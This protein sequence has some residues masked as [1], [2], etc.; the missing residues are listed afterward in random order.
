MATIPPNLARVA[1]S[2]SGDLLLRNMRRTNV[3]LLRLQSQIASGKKI[4]QPSDEP[5]SISSINTLQAILDRIASQNNLVKRAQDVNDVT[6]Q[7]LS[8]VSTALLQAQDVASSQVGV[9]TNAETRANQAAVVDGIIDGLLRIAN[10]DYDNLFVFGGL[11]SDT[12]PFTSE[13]GGIR[14]VGSRSNLLGETADTAF[15]LELNSNG[16]ASLG[17]LSRRV[18]SQVDLD[19][20]V[21]AQTRIADVHGARDLGVAKGA[22]VLDVDGTQVQVDLTTSDTL[23]DVVTRINSAINAIDNTAGSLSINPAGFTLTASAGHTIT[24]GDLGTGVTAADLGINLTA[25]AG[26]V[27]GGD[28]DPRLILITPLSQLGVSVDLA[29]GIRIVNGSVTKDISF[30]AATT[31]QDLINAVD[32]AHIG[33]RLEINAAG[34]GFNL[35]NEVSGANMSVGELGGSTAADLGLRSFDASTS[36][37]DFNHGDGVRILGNS[38]ADFRIEV[39]DGTLVDVS[40][41]GATDVQDVLDAV[42]TAGAGKVS[43][44]LAST[45]NGIVLTDLSGGAGQFKVI[46]INNSFAAQD[47]GISKNATGSTTLAGDD[48]AQIRTESVFT[49]LIALRDALRNNDIGGITEAGT[50]IQADLSRVA[51]VRA[52]IGVRSDR[53]QNELARNEDRTTQTQSILSDLRDTDMTEAISRFTQLQQQLQAN[54]Q[55]AGQLLRL[56]L[57]DFLQ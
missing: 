22:V 52:T 56:T 29:G 15:P 27:S 8:D 5:Q 41:T 21:A 46:Q 13:F 10:R 57:L 49:H 28:L 44:A 39:G 54:L 40:L 32:A 18:T 25:S 42:N 6:D 2:L 17:A 11:R 4:S 16:D 33:A 34:T 9:T 7:A 51:E 47:L 38:T 36:L 55:T 1:T 48:T 31:I 37:S 53:I 3:D 43:A 45:G 30:A 50:R 12:V 20:Q 23:A 35:V 14:Y 24:L 19:P 26:S